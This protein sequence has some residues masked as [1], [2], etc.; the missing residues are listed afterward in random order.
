MDND[1]DFFGDILFDSTS[2]N[3]LVGYVENSDDCND[4]NAEINPLMSE[5]CNGID[6]NCNI[7]VDEGLTI[8][9]M[10]ADVDGD[11]FGNPDAAVDTCIETIA[12]YVNNSLDCNDTIADI[13]PGAIELCNYLDDDCDGLADENLTYILSYQDNDGDNYGNP[14]IDSLSCELPIGYVEDD[15]DCDDTNGDIYPGAEEVLNGLDDDCDKLA[16]EGLSI[17]NLDYGFNIYPNPTQDFIYISNTLGLESSY[18][19]STTQGGVLLNET[20][21]TSIVIIDVKNY[22]SGMYLLIIQ[23]EFGIL[24]H[25]F[26]KK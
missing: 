17:E 1:G 21:F 6:D 26:I 10:Y 9:T 22:A 15:T 25:T 12:G 3:V 4:V 11:T 2:C 7:E 18:S 14:L 20:Y 8:Y 5:V 13:Y 19:I 23:T 24:T 16:D